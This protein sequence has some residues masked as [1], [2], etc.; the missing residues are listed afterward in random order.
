M[1]WTDSSIAPKIESAWMDGTKRKILVSE[2]LGYP[3]GLT[4]DYAG[5]HRVYWCDTKLDVIESMKMDG[6]NRVTVLTGNFSLMNNS[7]IINFKNS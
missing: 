5:G 7:F 3:T 4:I 1:Y 2:R 6:T